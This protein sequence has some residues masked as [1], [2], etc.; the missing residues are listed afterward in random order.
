MGESAVLPQFGRRVRAGVLPL[1]P[2]DEPAGLRARTLG[3]EGSVAR[4]STKIAEAL[5]KAT[6]DAERYWLWVYLAESWA[7]QC[8]AAA[9]EADVRDIVASVSFDLVPVDEMP[10]SRVDNSEDLDLDYLS[11]PLPRAPKPSRS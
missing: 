6:A 8:E 5:A 2:P 9:D 3:T 10:M 4:A 7:A 1:E 11:D